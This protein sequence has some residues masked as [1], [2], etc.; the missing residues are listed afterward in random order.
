M[1]GLEV[2]ET[3]SQKVKDRDLGGLEVREGRKEK[4]EKKERRK[5]ERKRRKIPYTYRISRLRLCFSVS[6]SERHLEVGWN[7]DSRGRK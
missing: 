1:G 7:A 4:M 5:E 6:G 3:F 2:P